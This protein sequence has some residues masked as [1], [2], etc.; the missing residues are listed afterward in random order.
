MRNNLILEEIQRFRLLSG[1]K[2]SKTL[3]ENEQE[4]EEQG[5]L[6]SMK[7]ITFAAKDIEAVVKDLETAFKAGKD[8][9]GG[10]AKVFRDFKLTNIQGGSK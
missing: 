10:A 8:G 4:I 3:T 6:G 1:Y 7:G 2:S 9:V 5:V